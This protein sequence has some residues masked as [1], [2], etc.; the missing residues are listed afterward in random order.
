MGGAGGGRQW[1]P[2]GRAAWIGFSLERVPAQHGEQQATGDEDQEKEEPEDQPGEGGGHDAPEALKHSLDRRE[3]TWGEQGEAE[4]CGR[5]EEQP[6]AQRCAPT[7]PAQSGE[8]D[9]DGGAE[10]GAEWGHRSG[11]ER[12]AVTGETQNENTRENENDSAAEDGGGR[13]TEDRGRRT[14]DG[15]RRTEDG[16][17]K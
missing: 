15:R 7:Q 6:E 17:A 2:I 3:Q 1:F 10:E 16:S 13:R 12:T 5:E 11:G 4:E 9:G 8:R 14:E